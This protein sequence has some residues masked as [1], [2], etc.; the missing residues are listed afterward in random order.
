MED[1]KLTHASYIQ[2]WSLICNDRTPG[3]HFEENICRQSLFSNSVCTPPNLIMFRHFIS[4]SG[5]LVPLKPCT[6][7]EPLLLSGEN[8][9]KTVSLYLKHACGDKGI[10]IHRRLEVTTVKEAIV[11]EKNSSIRLFTF[12]IS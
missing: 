9:I 6:N 11:L 4:L 5:P 3:D 2:N 8:S 12:S 10:R 1:I 7:L